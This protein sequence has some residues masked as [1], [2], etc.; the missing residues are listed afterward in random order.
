[1]QKYFVPYNN[2]KPAYINVKGHN[3]VLVCTEGSELGKDLSYF[4]AN[5]VEEIMI[6]ESQIQQE[7]FLSSL[8][9]KI[10][11]GVV[12]A[13]PGVDIKLILDGLENE[14]PWMH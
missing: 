9:K 3:L 14:L 13:P 7:N 11:G 1:M 10:H 8:A 5:R 6:G 2:E 4:G 12:L